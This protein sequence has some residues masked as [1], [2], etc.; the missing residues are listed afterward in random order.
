MSSKR[1]TWMRSSA[2][3]RPSSAWVGASWH[4]P[5]HWPAVLVALAPYRE[6][7][8]TLLMRVLAARGNVAEALRAYDDLRVRLRD[9]LGIAPCP[10]VQDVHRTLL[11]QV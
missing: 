2:P 4:T 10:E 7:G 9:E 8:H 1:C 11:A 5:S 6:S 3:S